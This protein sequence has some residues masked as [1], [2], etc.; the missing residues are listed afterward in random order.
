[1]NLL[2]D[3]AKNSHWIA[4]A[5]CLGMDINLFFSDNN[6]GY[7]PFVKEVCAACPVIE[8]CLWYANETAS[9]HG[10]FAGMAPRDRLKWRRENKVILGMSREE[11]EARY[12]H[13]V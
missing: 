10:F 5:N 3:I 2:E 7:D 9:D 6:H 8:E 13:A 11:W 1:V 4:D 12:E